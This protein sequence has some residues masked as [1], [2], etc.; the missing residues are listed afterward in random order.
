MSRNS[1][2]SS[3]KT[4][5]CEELKAKLSQNK[6][7]KFSQETY[8]FSSLIGFS[9]S[10]TPAILPATEATPKATHNPRNFQGLAR[11]KKNLH[12]C[13]FQVF[14]QALIGRHRY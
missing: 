6:R 12:A 4:E 9:A 5:R 8:I 3:P 2:N 1:S 7:K 10:L 13:G 11:D 14:D